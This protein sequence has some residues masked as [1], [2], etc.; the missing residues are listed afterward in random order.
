VLGRGKKKPFVK[1]EES[2][3]QEKYHLNHVG[4]VTL[5]Q[6]ESKLIKVVDG[7]RMVSG[8]SCQEYAVDI[9]FQLSCSRTY[10]LFKIMALPRWR[11]TIFYVAVLL[12]II[13]IG[14]GYSYALLLNPL[15]LANLFAAWELSRIGIHNQTQTAF[16]PVIRAYIQYPTKMNFLTLLIFSASIIYIFQKL[17]TIQE[18][19]L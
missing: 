15:I 2:K 17:F 1:I 11:N 9:A 16:L 4:F 19:T 10:T 8:N 12:S 18:K 13:F 7:E 5:N 6:R 3:L 14:L